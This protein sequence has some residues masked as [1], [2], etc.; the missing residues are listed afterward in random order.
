MIECTQRSA[1][2]AIESDMDALDDHVHRCT[3]SVAPNTRSLTGAV[4]SIA[5]GH[6]PMIKCDKTWPAT[7]HMGPAASL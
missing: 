5:K 3:V 7:G 4:T 1:P 2:T 6:C